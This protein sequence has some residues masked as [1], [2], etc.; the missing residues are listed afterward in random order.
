[1][2]NTSTD[3]D[4][5]FYNDYLY[6]MIDAAG[7][8]KFTEELEPYL[9]STDTKEITDLAGGVKTMQVNGR[10]LYYVIYVVD[11]INF[12]EF[13]LEYRISARMALNDDIRVEFSCGATSDKPAAL[14]GKTETD[15]L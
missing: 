9:K 1:M 2:E 13:S 14:L 11:H 5:V 3:K 4:D 8:A 7:Y 15:Y 10:T 6:A 12:P